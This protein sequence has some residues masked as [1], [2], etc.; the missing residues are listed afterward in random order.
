MGAF[1]AGFSLGYQQGANQPSR[2]LRSTEIFNP[3]RPA[4]DHD[5]DKIYTKEHLE[6]GK[7]LPGCADREKAMESFQESIE[8]ADLIIPGRDNLL[9]NPTGTLRSPVR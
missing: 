2:F 1:Y 6:Q 3:D 8:I 5:S 7:V 9:V 4:H